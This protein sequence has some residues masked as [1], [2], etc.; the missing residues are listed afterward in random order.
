MIEPRY[1]F[2]AL[3]GSE[4]KV[5]IFITLRK[6]IPWAI[7]EFL[8]CTTLQETVPA[9]FITSRT[10][11]CTF[12][13]LLS[14]SKA[15]EAV[16]LEASTIGTEDNKIIIRG[17][18]VLRL[19]EVP[20]PSTQEEGLVI[21]ELSIQQIPFAKLPDL[22]FDSPPYV[23]YFRCPN[24]NQA[25]LG[26]STTV[27][28]EDM[29]YCPF[30]H[31]RYDCIETDESPGSRR[32]HLTISCNAYQFSEAREIDLF[33]VPQF[34]SISPARVL[35]DTSSPTSISLKLFEN[36]RFPIEIFFEK[37]FS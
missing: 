2:R 32:L 20:D 8:Q 24:G 14:S 3:K 5:P 12:S 33:A 25:L 1:F 11:K 4:E 19:Y 9:Y 17:T 35:Q 6:S 15:S 22:S 10:V 36:E 30:L 16:A 23:C 37:Y 27:L 34:S 28:I 18:E 26:T 29:L 31:L 21:P 7:S 13:N